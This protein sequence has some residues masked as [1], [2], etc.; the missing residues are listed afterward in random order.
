MKMKA[1]MFFRIQGGIGNNSS[2][3]LF[4]VD[5]NGV[6]SVKNYATPVYIS[7]PEHAYRWVI[8]RSK[9][10]ADNFANIARKNMSIVRIVAPFWLCALFYRR[11]ISNARP[12]QRK[13]VHICDITMSGVSIGLKD[14]WLQL[15]CESA[16]FA[17]HTALDAPERINEVLTSCLVTSSFPQRKYDGEKV[18]GL[19]QKLDLSK[20]DITLVRDCDPV[21]NPEYPLLRGGDL[22][23]QERSR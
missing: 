4:S 2:A 16:L 9:D 6:L 23:K 15:L 22:Q 12:F 20:E 19:L 3:A 13:N 18:S 14:I 7:N 5:E 1:E 10:L 8:K 17:D 21:L 11:A